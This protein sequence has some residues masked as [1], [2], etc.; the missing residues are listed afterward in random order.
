VTSIKLKIK[1]LNLSALFLNNFQF[2]KMSRMRKI[3][4]II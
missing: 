1:I 2:K 3:S 4:F